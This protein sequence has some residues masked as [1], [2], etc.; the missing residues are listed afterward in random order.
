M[1]PRSL[2]S[3][4]FW[5]FP[6]A[7]I[8]IGVVLGFA[9]F[10]QSGMGQDSSRSGDSGELRDITGIEQMPLAP[11]RSWWAYGLAV[12][13]LLLTG[14][15]LAGWRYWRRFHGEGEPAPG[16]WALG[17]LARIDSLNLSEVGQVEKYHTLCSQVI[18]EYLEKRFQ[19]GASRQTTPEFLQTMAHSS[20]LGSAEQNMLKEFLERCDL[21][22]FARVRFP[23]EDC[24]ALGQSARLFVEKTAMDL[25][26]KSTS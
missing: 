12:A 11:A 3:E 13:V 18:R 22:K 8:F 16:S 19:V 21:A 25:S 23:N 15:F 6:K 1:F 4:L 7:I 17:E 10:V 2:Y 24:R 5:S 14:M 26:A 9:Y 20:L